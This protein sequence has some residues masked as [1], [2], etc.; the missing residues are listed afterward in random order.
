MSVL[1]ILPSTQECKKNKFQNVIL[2]ATKNV[3]EFHYRKNE[4]LFFFCGLIKTIEITQVLQF[5]K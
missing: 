4:H 5:L 3:V 1:N 2:F